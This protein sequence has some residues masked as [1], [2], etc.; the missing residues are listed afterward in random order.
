MEVKEKS[1]KVFDE[2]L[3]VVQRH[4]EVQR[5]DFKE[6]VRSLTLGGLEIDYD[7]RKVFCNGQEIVLTVKEYEMLCLLTAHRGRV[8]AYEQIYQ[9]IWGE[10]YFGNAHNAVGCHIRN[11]RRKLH[12]TY[13]NA[14]FKIKCI[15]EVGYCFE[16]DKNYIQTESSSDI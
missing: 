4:S 1:S 9:N 14:P 6:Q 12:R 2:I 16:L 10:E 11:V 7:S 13:P 8:L 15:R 3:E 5:Y